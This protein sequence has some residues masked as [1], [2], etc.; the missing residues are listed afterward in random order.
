MDF[1]FFYRYLS[2]VRG[3]G[4]PFHAGQRVTVPRMAVEILAVDERGLPVEAA[5]E[6]DVPLEDASLKWLCWNWD[7]KRYEAFDVPAVG[8]GRELV[9]PF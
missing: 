8:G 3:A 7:R 6:F 2:D 9:G 5:F 1:V 4:H